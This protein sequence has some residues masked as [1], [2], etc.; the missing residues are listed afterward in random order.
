MKRSPM[1]ILPVLLVWSA[2]GALVCGCQTTQPGRVPV[3]V[4]EIENIMDSFHRAASEADYDGYVGRLTPDGI[5]LGTDPTE[6]WTRDE[7]GG[8]CRP[9]FDQGTGWTYRPVERHVA[10]QGDVA[11]VDEILENEKYGLCRGTA[12]LVR[13]GPD[14]GIAHYSLTFLVPND[15]S[16]G[17]VAAIQAASQAR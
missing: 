3:P 10:S 4:S 8:F 11:W 14:L 15:A 7:L 5:F 6:R 16:A 1:N 12:V 17:V 9:Y 2:L 13:E